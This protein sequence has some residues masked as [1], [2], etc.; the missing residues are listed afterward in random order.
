MERGNHTESNEVKEGD[1][2]VCTVFF[3]QLPNG[4]DSIRSPGSEAACGCKHADDVF[5]TEFLYKCADARYVR[6]D[7][8]SI[9]F[10]YTIYNDWCL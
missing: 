6:L 3:A 5:C 2:K 1:N 7:M 9:S 8:I 10:S 4:I